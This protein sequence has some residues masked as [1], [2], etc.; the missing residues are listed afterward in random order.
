MESWGQRPMW[1]RS[2]IANPKPAGGELKRRGG[3]ENGPQ[4]RGHGLDE[5]GEEKTGREVVLVEGLREG[6]LFSKYGAQ[7]SCRL[8]KT[9]TETR[10]LHLRLRLNLTPLY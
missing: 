10:Q 4:D 7:A 3:F 2:Q 5:E 8:P 1:G 6:L 9:K